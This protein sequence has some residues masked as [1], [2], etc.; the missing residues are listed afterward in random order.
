MIAGAVFS[1][2]QASKYLYFKKKKQQFYSDT[3]NFIGANF[4]NLKRRE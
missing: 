3:L 4:I 1:V 2:V